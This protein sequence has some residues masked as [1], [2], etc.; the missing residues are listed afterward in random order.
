MFKIKSKSKVNCLLVISVLLRW[1]VCISFLCLLIKVRGIQMCE[2]RSTIEVKTKKQNK[3]KKTPK[4]A[5]SWTSINTQQWPVCFFVLDVT[6]S[7]TTLTWILT[8]EVKDTWKLKSGHN[9]HWEIPKTNTNSSIGWSRAP[10]S[11][12]AFQIWIPIQWN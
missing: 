1:F 6:D 3:T 2:Q 8:L 5:I 11:T 12:R 4:Q 7:N 9:F 10:Q